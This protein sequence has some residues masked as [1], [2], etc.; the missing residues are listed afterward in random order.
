[1][2]T[3]NRSSEKVAQ[4]KYLGMTVTNQNLILEE[5]KWRLNM[6]MLA[7]IQCNNCSLCRPKNVKIRI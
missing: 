5:I 6:G 7:T 3:A 4:L 1:M 2:T